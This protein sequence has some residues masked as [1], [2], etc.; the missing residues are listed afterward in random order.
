MKPTVNQSGKIS[1]GPRLPFW[2]SDY[3]QIGN[4][5]PGMPP[6]IYGTRKTKLYIAERREKAGFTQKQL[7]DL[8]GVSDVTVSR[9]E[10]GHREPDLGTQMAICEAL[11]GNIQ[12]ADLHYHPDRPS[13]DEL[14]RGQPRDVVENAFKVI[15][16]IRR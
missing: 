12:P 7:G 3:N 1:Q 16:A 14:L 10:T 6:R 2:R 5:N 8:L 9:W 11:G 13:A 4:D 15:R